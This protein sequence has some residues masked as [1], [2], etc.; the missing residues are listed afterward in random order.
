[1]YQRFNFLPDSYFYIFE[2]NRLNFTV[3][4]S[5][6]NVT[7]K[8]FEMLLLT[9]LVIRVLIC[10]G[11]NKPERMEI[12]VTKLMEEYFFSGLNNFFRNLL[13]LMSIIYHTVMNYIKENLED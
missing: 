9:I 1:M 2:L 8:Q 11:L 7:D 3:F 13:M 4:G 12:K 5:L 6:N 10:E